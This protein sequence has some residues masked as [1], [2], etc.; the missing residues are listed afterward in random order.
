[1]IKNYHKILL[2]SE[3]HIKPKKLY[4]DQVPKLA[5]GL[6]RL[7]HDVSHLSYTGI[8][9][10]LSPFK[11]RT[12]N[13]RFY[14][15]KTDATICEYAKHF[16]PDIV[17]IGFSRGLDKQTVQALRATLPTAIFFGWDGDP[18]PTNNPGRI[19][20]A[21]ELDILFATNNGEFLDEYKKQG[22]KKCLF[23]PNLI[24]PDND[25]RYDVGKPWQSDILWTGKI[26]HQVGIDAGETVRQNVLSKFSGQSGVK[27]YGCLGYSEIG[28]IDYLYAISGARIGI[29]INAINTVPFY[30][31][32]R[33]THYS[34][35]GAMVLAKRV[36]ETD[37]LMEDNKHVRYFDTEEECREL[38]DWYLKHEKERQAIADAGNKHCHAN[39]NSVQMAGH[40]INAIESGQ[41]TAPWGIFS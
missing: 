4:V 22:I 26:Q 24:D 2:I 18:S 35:C 7:G 41:Y 31:S 14:K 28:G 20:L 33:F 16:R 23:M 6:I 25:H 29:S 8:M 13:H 38:A 12:I 19:E 37:C 10:Q 5:K 32:D 30:H 1:M 27:I 15:N 9:A 17:F 21:C 11:S 36:P 34:A 40:I 3:T 39:Y